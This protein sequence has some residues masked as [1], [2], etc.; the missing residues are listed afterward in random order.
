MES[1]V[2]YLNCGIISFRLSPLSLYINIYIYIYICNIR[3]EEGKDVVD[4][5]VHSFS[6]ITEN[7]IPFF[8]K[9]P[10]LVPQ[11]IGKSKDFNLS[12]MYE[13]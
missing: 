9:Y 5:H 10:I 7:I 1:I 11:E 13:K 4:F 3:W 6:Q 12:I 8:T 2:G